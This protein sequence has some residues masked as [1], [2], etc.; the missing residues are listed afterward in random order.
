MWTEEMLSTEAVATREKPNASETA[1]TCSLPLCP[2][3]H[4]RCPVE[5]LSSAQGDGTPTPSSTAI[6]WKMLVYLTI[7]KHS[8][9]TTV[10]VPSHVE[11]MFQEGHRT[12]QSVN[13]IVNR[14][15]VNLGPWLGLDYLGK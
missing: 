10:Q 1:L 4:S 15:D 5:L 11:F 2:L 14:C 12:K 7:A 6:I 3:P 13:K 8:E 9:S